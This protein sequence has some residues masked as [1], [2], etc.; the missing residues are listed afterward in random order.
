MKFIDEAIITVTSGKGGPGC[1][2]FRRERFIERG[3]PDGGNGGNGGSIILKAHAG[4]RSLFDIYR[5]KLVK[6]KNG[7]PGLGKKKHGK[8]GAHTIIETPPGTLITNAETGEFL[9]DLTNPG[10]EFV[11]VKGGIGGKG[12]KHFASSTNKAPRF[13]QPGMPG[14]EL[15]LKFELKLL[16]DIGIVGL[17]NAGKSTLI[18]KISSARPKVA[19]YPFTTITPSLGMVM[20]EFGEPFAVADI[21]GLIEGAHEGTGLGTRFLKHIERTGFLIHLIDIFQTDPDSPLNAFNLINRELAL[22]S[23]KLAK[24][25]QIVVLNKIDLTGA[26][27]KVEIFKKA[28]KEKNIFTISAATGRGTKELVKFLAKK[29]GREHE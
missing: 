13:A 17:P 22:H 3:G 2:S 29:V 9:K 14:T 1:L 28:C 11:V 19:D 15:K 21:P 23:N 27:K 8:N 20:P 12:N 18:S 25:P 4:K 24:K 6:A 26:D 10:D 5:S 16:A 7:M